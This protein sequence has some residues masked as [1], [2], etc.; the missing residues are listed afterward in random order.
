MSALWLCS[1]MVI[2]KDFILPMMTQLLVGTYGDEST[3]KIKIRLLWQ[4]FRRNFPWRIGNHEPSWL[5]EVCLL[6]MRHYAGMGI[7]CYCVSVC[8]SV[9]HLLILYWNGCAD[10]ADFFEYRFPLTYAMLCF[11]EIWVSPIIRVLPFGTLSQTLDFGFRKFCHSTPTVGECNIN[12]DS[13][14]TCVYCLVFTV[15]LAADVHGTYAMAQTPLVW[16]LVDLLWIC[17]TARHLPTLGVELCYIVQLSIA[18]EGHHR[19]DA[20]GVSW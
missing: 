14:Q 17:C 7:S 8:L 3:C 5:L 13:S 16:F 10:Q 4:V 15:L 18:C 20:I 1:L 6:P 12:C 9:H 11:K 19:V 2:C